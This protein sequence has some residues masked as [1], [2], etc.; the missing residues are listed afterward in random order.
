MIAAELVTEKGILLLQPQGKLEAKDFENI[1]TKVDSYLQSQ[2]QLKGIIVEA[3]KFPGWKDFASLVAH[4]R[5]VRDHHK[6]VAKIA[7]VSDDSV[8]SKAPQVASHFV[9]AE[10]KHYAEGQREAAMKWI[11]G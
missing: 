10:I 9:A 7:I 11:E 5:F 8:L 3:E 2:P 1:A 6:Q 4:L